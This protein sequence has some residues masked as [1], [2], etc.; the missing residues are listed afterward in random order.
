MVDKYQLI[1]KKMDTPIS[2]EKNQNYVIGKN[3]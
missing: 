2:Y 1:F 3:I